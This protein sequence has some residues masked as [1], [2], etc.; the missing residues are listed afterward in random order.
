MVTMRPLFSLPLFWCLINGK[1]FI[2]IVS[3]SNDKGLK[4]ESDLVLF[5][6]S[7]N[8]SIVDRNAFGACILK[9]GFTW[10]L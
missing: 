2:L 8:R 10:P 7:C 3:Y 1:T 5:S 4:S 6:I 9:C